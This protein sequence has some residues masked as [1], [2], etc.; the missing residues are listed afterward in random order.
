MTTTPSSEIFTTPALSD[1]AAIISA[2]V[3]GW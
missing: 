1:L 3:T 2:Y